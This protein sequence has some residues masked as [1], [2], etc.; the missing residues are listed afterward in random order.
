MVCNKCGKEFPV[1]YLNQY[2]YKRGAKY[3]CSWSCMRKFDKEKEKMN[4]KVDTAPA[5]RPGRPKKTE[6]PAVLKVDG[7]LKIETPEANKVTVAEIPEKPK[8]KKPVSFG[9]YEVTAIRHPVLGEFY[10]DQK[11][12]RIDWRTPEGDEVSMAPENWRAF[13]KAIPEIMGVLGVKV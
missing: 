6:T 1:L 8:G 10:Y 2:V 12:N 5:K 9:D 3:F 4:K 7:P 13:T 11:F